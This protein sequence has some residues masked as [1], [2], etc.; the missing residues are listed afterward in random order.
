[1]NAVCGDNW[2]NCAWF[3]WDGS[4]V[5]DL[6]EASLNARKWSALAW[7]TSAVSL[8]GAFGKFVAAALNPLTESAVYSTV[9]RWPKL[10]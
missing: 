2:T 1:M 7:I 5:D 4:P 6:N 10:K 3:V 8:I 9:C